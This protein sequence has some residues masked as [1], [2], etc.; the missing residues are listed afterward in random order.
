MKTS[1]AAVV[2]PLTA[3]RARTKVFKKEGIQQ[4][5][6]TNN[7]P[8]AMRKGEGVIGGGGGVRADNSNAID[9]KEEGKRGE[10]KP[11]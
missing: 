10:Q 1:T 7:N 5:K 2:L 6:K 3:A 11:L 8:R 4:T 9:R